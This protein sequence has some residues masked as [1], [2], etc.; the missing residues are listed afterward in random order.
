LPL[1]TAQATFFLF[2]TLSASLTQNLECNI[3]VNQFSTLGLS[4]TLFN[5]GS[6]V[7]FVLKHPGFNIRL[8]THSLILRLQENLPRSAI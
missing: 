6:D 4:K 7:F 8:L 2:L 5:V 3:A 1:I